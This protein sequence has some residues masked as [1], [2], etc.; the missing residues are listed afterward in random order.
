[1]LDLCILIAGHVEMTTATSCFNPFLYLFALLLVHLACF[2][3][4][5]SGGEQQEPSQFNRRRARRAAPSS[6]LKASTSAPAKTPV[7]HSISL[8]S[9][10][11]QGLCFLMP[12]NKEPEQ[13]KTETAAAVVL[14]H[15]YRYTSRFN[16]YSCPDCGED[17]R[18]PQLLDIHRSTKHSFSDLSCSD[19]GYNVVR[20]IF[21]AGWK[22]RGPVAVHRLLKIHHSGRTLAR[23]EEYRA[24]VRSRAETIVV[25]GGGGEERCVADGNER[26]GFYS[27]TCLCG[28]GGG[29][30]GVGQ[31]EACPVVRRGSFAGK[32]G[33]EL[34]V[35]ATHATGWGAHVAPAA[36]EMRQ[37][38]E[39][40]VIVMCRVVAGR[41][42]HGA[43]AAEKKAAVAEGFDSV[44]PGCRS[45][46]GGEED[47][48]LLVFSP[49]ALL[50][51]FVII[52][53]A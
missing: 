1:M 19:P 15:E 45:F 6:L 33:R 47:E 24:A 14:D 51:C 11:A 25:G 43:A 27:T 2:F 3:F 21:F 52:Y 28:L 22:G 41:V 37:A 39:R 46:A 10:L 48:L 20:I 32:S 17:F 12:K 40:K 44:I 36:R 8:R 35:M 23:F 31:C 34:G 42:A 53:T 9:C 13:R 5:P 18:I 49:K 38:G 4:P 26:L 7:K 30:C 16:M 29:A 50:P